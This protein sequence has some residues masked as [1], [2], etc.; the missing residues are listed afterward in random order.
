MFFEKRKETFQFEKFYT[1][2]FALEMIPLLVFL[3]DT[4]S[5]TSDGQLLSISSATAK[6]FD[7]P[8]PPE[9]AIDGLYY[10]IYHTVYQNATPG[11]PQWLKLQL[12][13]PALVSRVVIVNR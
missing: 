13:E 11:P 2:L 5:S 6:T 1:S 4:A 9:N 12:E 8:S 7:P 10:T 3:L